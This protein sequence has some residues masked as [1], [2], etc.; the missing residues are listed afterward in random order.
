[1]RSRELEE[2]VQPALK[3]ATVLWVAMLAAVVFYAMAAH[4]AIGGAQGDRSPIGEEVVLAL[5]MV[6]AVCAVLSFVLPA[7]LL[8]DAR[9]R[10][11]MQVED[12]DP[13]KYLRNPKTG[14][15]NYEQVE[16]VSRLP[17]LEQRL[18]TLPS[19][20]FTPMIVG[21]AMSEAVAVIGFILAILTRDIQWMLL[22]AIV[23]LALLAF[24]RPRFD[25]L[26]DR[27]T[28]LAGSR[29]SP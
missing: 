23:A 12:F 5:A 16:R 18:A 19:L 6:A 20:Y 1:M 17:E 10:E 25:P 3:A 11:R 9:L 28:R 7:K 8:S 24:K 22:F 29:P 26:F 27:A 15:V 21:M 13:A 4:L 14:A 2:A